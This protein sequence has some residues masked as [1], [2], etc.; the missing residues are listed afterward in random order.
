MADI[1]IGKGWL[2]TFLFFILLSLA[3]GIFNTSQISNGD[4]HTLKESTSYTDRRMAEQKVYVD[5][6]SL[7][8]REEYLGIARQQSTTNRYLIFLSCTTK[9]TTSECKQEQEELDQLQ[10]ESQQLPNQ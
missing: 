4:S 3:I 5:Q 7:E 6:R 2:G 9:K 10:L 1:N 8:L